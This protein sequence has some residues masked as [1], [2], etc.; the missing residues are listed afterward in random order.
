MSTKI[1]EK[2][3][4][5]FLGNS[6]FN[7]FD[8]MEMFFFLN[9]FTGE[10]V[11]KEYADAYYNGTLCELSDDVK[12]CRY[13]Y[14]TDFARKCYDRVQNEEGF[15]IKLTD[16]LIEHYFT[17]Y[18]NDELFTIMF[19]RWLKLPMKQVHRLE[20]KGNSSKTEQL[21]KYYIC[22]SEGQHIDNI[23]SCQYSG[24]YYVG[25]SKLSA[26]FIGNG[27]IQVDST[28]EILLLAHCWE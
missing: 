19:A 17:E 16:E 15:N 7:F 25:D 8:E 6:Q 12:A 10:C 22:L 11:S 23:D 3:M 27:Q 9:G 26:H 14:I 20:R 18:S 13:L 21:L 28:G 1:Y 2:L 4:E 24:V 5:Y